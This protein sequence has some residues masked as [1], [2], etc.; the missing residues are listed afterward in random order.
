LPV[1]QVRE[2]IVES[3]GAGAG[4]VVAAALFVVG[5]EDQAGVAGCL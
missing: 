3:R 2:Q 4:I 1:D 5:Q